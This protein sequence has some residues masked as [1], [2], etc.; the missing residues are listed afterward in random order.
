[1]GGSFGAGILV[2]LMIVA[3]IIIYKRGGFGSGRECLGLLLRFVDYYNYGVMLPSRP[4]YEQISS[5]GL[6]ESRVSLA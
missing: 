2:C 3:G 5:T 1:M 4:L 6:L